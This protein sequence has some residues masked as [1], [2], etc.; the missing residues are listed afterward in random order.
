M[1]PQKKYIR[2]K[3][4]NMVEVPMEPNVG[5]NTGMV[6]PEGVKPDSVAGAVYNAGQSAAEG[7]APVKKG[8]GLMMDAGNAVTEKG[9]AIQQGAEKK[10]DSAGAGISNAIKRMSGVVPTD[11]DI[12]AAASGVKKTVAG[13]IP[14]PAAAVFSF[15]GGEE[16]RAGGKLAREKVAQGEIGQGVGAAIQTLRNTLGG[17]IAD[18]K[19]SV[20][21]PALKNV[22]DVVIPGW[23]QAGSN[24]RAGMVA[25]GAE[26]GK[27]SAPVQEPSKVVAPEPKPPGVSSESEQQ[28]QTPATE[29]VPVAPAAP[30]APAAVSQTGRPGVQKTKNAQGE[31]VFSMPGGEVTVK[32]GAEKVSREPA[33]TSGTTASTAM[34]ERFMKPVG[35]GATFAERGFGAVDGAYEDQKARQGKP[36]QTFPAGRRGE[37]VQAD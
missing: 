21:D 20:V 13:A 9:Q 23:K 16:A 10:L 28:A 30:A 11:K 4:G 29:P 12:A 36:R 5:K 15:P 8:Y 17:G 18:V 25:A 35:R 6:Y 19:E 14:D 3:D 26:P 2:D 31:W 1:A 24:I 27:P 33:A 37:Q 22:K 34:R 7:V 32:G